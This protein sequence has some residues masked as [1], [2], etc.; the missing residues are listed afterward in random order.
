ML[1][2]TNQTLDIMCS[3]FALY[4]Q[5]QCSMRRCENEDDF[6]DSNGAHQNDYAFRTVNLIKKVPS[7]LQKKSIFTELPI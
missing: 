1:K 7:F 6:Y 5:F 4:T 3:N 2:Y